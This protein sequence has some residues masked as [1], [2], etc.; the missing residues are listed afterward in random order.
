VNIRLK[1]I[2]RPA[3]QIQRKITLAVPPQPVRKALRLDGVKTFE[4]Q[5]WLNQ[6]FG[7]GVALQYGHNVGP[8]RRVDGRFRQHGPAGGFDQH[9]RIHDIVFQ[10][11]HD[12]VKHR[13]LEK[14]LLQYAIQEERGKLGSAAI[15][16][17]R[18]L[19]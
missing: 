3:L 12:P 13:S 6:T 7:R 15:R 17:L 2:R 8:D 9:F 14:R 1:N 5:E 19:P 4:V 11:H 18:F 10:A 16:L